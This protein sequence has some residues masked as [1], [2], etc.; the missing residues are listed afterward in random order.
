MFQFAPRRRG[1]HGH[2]PCTGREG[3]PEGRAQ[4]GGRVRAETGRSRRRFR[5]I[6]VC[7]APHPQSW[8]IVHCT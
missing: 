5:G 6:A 7:C 8:H 3:G 1:A 2:G 4:T